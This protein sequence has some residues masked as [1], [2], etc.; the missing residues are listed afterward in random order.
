[1]PAQ[2]ER[3]DA[4]SEG[5]D[6]VGVRIGYEYVAVTPI[7]FGRTWDLAD[8]ATLRIEPKQ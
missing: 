6:V 5:L 2:F 8:G 7:A 3:K 4:L 1:M